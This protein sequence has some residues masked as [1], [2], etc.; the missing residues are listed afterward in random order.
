[1]IARFG[2]ALSMAVW[3]SWL[4][5]PSTVPAAPRCEARWSD[6]PV[7]PAKPFHLTV[8][9]Q[10]DGDAADWAVRPPRADLPEGLRAGPVSSRSFREGEG[11]VVRFRMEMTAPEP[12][13][14]PGFPLRLEVFRAGAEEPLE[15][16]INTE[17]L[18]VAS[19]RWKGVPHG[20]LLAGAAL[21]VLLLLIGC[22]IR[23]ARNRKRRGR[24]PPSAAGGKAVEG[25][26]HLTALGE[27]LNACRVRGD[28]LG[29]LETALEIHRRA[30]PQETPEFH[31][32]RDRLEQARYGDLRLSG[33]EMD[34]WHRK[35]KR[36]LK[37]AGLA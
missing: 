22:A 36:L 13:L 30:H 6:N 35:L 4:V 15:E 27:T 17:P 23:L 20:T 18:R 11:N 8:T 1:M 26:I 24:V 31:E 12:G 16:V 19:G 33:E 37:P 28:T 29:F 3:L 5:L 25:S 7:S 32:I 14:V 21:T 9:A 10:W 2:T 34:A